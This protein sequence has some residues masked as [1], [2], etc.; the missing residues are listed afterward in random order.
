MLYTDGLFLGGTNHKVQ[1]ISKSA[2][3]N[4]CLGS[5]ALTESA[6]Q[7]RIMNPNS[8][9]II[10]GEGMSYFDTR[11]NAYNHIFCKYKNCKQ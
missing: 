6:G 1:I 8:S 11:Y 9:N 5:R 7:K 10:G 3:Y 2:I 4:N